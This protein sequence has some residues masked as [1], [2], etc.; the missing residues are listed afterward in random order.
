MNIKEMTMWL[1]TAQCLCAVDAV[2]KNWREE[3]LCQVRIND[4]DDG[5]LLRIVHETKIKKKH[6]KY[7]KLNG[8]LEE[9]R[10]IALLKNAMGVGMD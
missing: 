7:H 2:V 3:L 5:H 8:Y 1:V 9:E 4:C 6:I 10:M